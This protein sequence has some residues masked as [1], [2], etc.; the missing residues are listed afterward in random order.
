MMVAET[1]VLTHVRAPLK[2]LPQA[3]LDPMPPVPPKRTT[4]VNFVSVSKAFVPKN[5]LQ[6]LAI[7]FQWDIKVSRIAVFV[8]I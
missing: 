5:G 3:V 6:N 1:W 7:R 8:A 2:P 4:I